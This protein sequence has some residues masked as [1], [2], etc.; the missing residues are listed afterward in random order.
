MSFQSILLLIFSDII[1]LYNKKIKNN[2]INFGDVQVKINELL[3]LTLLELETFD[4]LDI[5]DKSEF[6][7]SGSSKIL[8]FS[9]YQD[10]LLNATLE[11]NTRFIYVFQLF[12]TFLYSV[13]DK[14][15]FLQEFSFESGSA[16]KKFIVQFCKTY[17]EKL[18]VLCEEDAIK[19]GV[20]L[21]TFVKSLISIYVGLLIIFA[22]L[23]S[24]ILKPYTPDFLEKKATNTNNTAFFFKKMS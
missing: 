10:I 3:N 15:I 23:Y 20:S 12:E 19:Y 13:Q 5:L 14:T 24:G 4:I 1:L 7:K 21:K 2:K 16:C 18:K 11:E 22:Y 9:L 8:L 6:F 17:P